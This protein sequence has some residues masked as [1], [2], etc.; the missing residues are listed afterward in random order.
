MSTQPTEVKYPKGATYELWVIDTGDLEGFQVYFEDHVIDMVADSTT[1]KY[2]L[3]R[4][5]APTAVGVVFS[6]TDGG[7][8]AIVSRTATGNKVVAGTTGK[9]HSYRLVPV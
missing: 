8:S 4:P 2:A 3:A 7:K 5:G 1:H 9:L 6:G